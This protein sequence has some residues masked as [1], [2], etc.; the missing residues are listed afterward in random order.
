[1]YAVSIGHMCSFVLYNSLFQR[2]FMFCFR[3]F[4]RIK[5]K[6]WGS[7]TPKYTRLAV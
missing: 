7:T 2:S 3:L 4:Y 5:P 6:H 1:M